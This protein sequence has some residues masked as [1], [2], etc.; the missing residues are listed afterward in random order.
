MFFLSVGWTSIL[1]I[2][3]VR[4]RKSIFKRNLMENPRLAISAFAM[5]VL[6]ALFVIVPP[7]ASIFKLVPISA[8][9]WLAAIGLSIVPTIT[10]ELGKLV[11]NKTE[12]RQYK[13]RLVRH[14][15]EAD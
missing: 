5:I 6:F 8:G 9:H 14:L 15:A 12:T 10:A 3:T 11:Q 7:F 4:S 1:H 13:H 2:F